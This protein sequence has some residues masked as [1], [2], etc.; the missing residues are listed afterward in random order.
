MEHLIWGTIS[1][2]PGACLLHN[3]ATKIRETD[4]RVVGD[5]MVSPV[6]VGGKQKWIINGRS[7]SGEPDLLPRSEEGV[8]D[9]VAPC[10]DLP[11]GMRDT[12]HSISRS[13]YRPGR[14]VLPTQWRP[15]D[16][17]PRLRTREPRGGNIA[18]EGVPN[19][20]PVASLIHCED[21]RAAKRRDPSPQAKRCR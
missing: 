17:G 19:P 14:T 21:V 13:V 9:F 1:A 16:R 7:G 20:E 5:A 15:N 4:G 6:H 2:D 18:V 11:G 10:E 8:P 3:A 12:W